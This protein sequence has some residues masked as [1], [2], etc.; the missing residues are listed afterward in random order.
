[1][2]FLSLWT[3]RP[4]RSARGRCFPAGG[5]REG[6]EQQRPNNG[7]TTT[8]LLY[9]ACNRRIWLIGHRGGR[10][11]WLIATNSGLAHTTPAIGVLSILALA[12]RPE[13]SAQ[14]RMPPTARSAPRGERRGLLVLTAGPV[15]DFPQ[16]LLPR[17]GGIVPTLM[18]ARGF[19]PS[20]SCAT[21]IEGREGLNTMTRTE[22]NRTAHRQGELTRDRGGLSV[23]REHA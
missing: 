17:P 5:L 21:P 12:L 1:M 23:Q 14:A 7:P 8:I 13:S 3:K 22:P 9:E 19:W 4:V 15:G 6:F 2:A 11:P 16:A 10:A 20:S 18:N